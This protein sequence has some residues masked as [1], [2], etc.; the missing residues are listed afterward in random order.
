MQNARPDTDV[1]LVDALAEGV[2]DHDVGNGIGCGAF[3][4]RVDTKMARDSAAA[5]Q[6]R[7]AVLL[8][9][10]SYRCNL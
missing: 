6:G 9:V 1:L 4:E 8:F 3:G 5:G 10:Y 2:A 7:S